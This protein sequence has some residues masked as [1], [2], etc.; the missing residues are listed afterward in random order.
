MHKPIG[1]SVASPESLMS[2]VLRALFRALI[3]FVHPRMLWL[4]IWPFLLAILF[5]SVV[6]WTF[7]GPALGALHDALFGLTLIRWVEGAFQWFGLASL[8]ALL[9]PIL[10]VGLLLSLA[11]ATAL[12]ILGTLAMPLVVDHVAARHH[13]TL[14]RRY[15]GSVAGSLLNA[16]VVIIIFIVGWVVTMPFWLILPLAFVLPWFWWAWLMSRVL[17]YD[18]LAQHASSEERQII[19]S[20]HRRGLLLVGFAV[21]ALNFVPPLFFVAPIYAG[22]TFTH[23]ALDA[24]ER[25]RKTDPGPVVD[26]RDAVGRMTFERIS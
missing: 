19:L 14:T 15:G 25:L 7:S 12:L 23:Y 13:P 1:K 24:L 2:S 3:S 10:Y 18:A 22:L 9:V 17:P 20:R 8:L 16:L 26:A 6:G 11:V 5:W 4:A 21:A